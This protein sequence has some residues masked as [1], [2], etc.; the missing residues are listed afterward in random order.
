V[1]EL[2]AVA[3]PDQAAATRA[4]DNLT[5]WARKGLVYGDDVIVIASEHD[6]LVAPEVGLT[7][8]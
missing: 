5:E 8:A 6:G 4:R 3:H 7:A 2:I 1:S